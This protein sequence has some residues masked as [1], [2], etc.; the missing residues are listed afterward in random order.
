MKMGRQY[1]VER[2]GKDSER[3][4]F[5]AR[6]QSY[7]GNTLGAL[8]LSGH[9][10][11]RSIYEGMLLPNVRHIPACNEYRDRQVHESTEQYVARKKQELEDMFQEI[12]PHR[13]IGFFLE[14]ISGAVSRISLFSILTL[15]RALVAVLL[16][17]KHPCSI[18]VTQQKCQAHLRL[19]EWFNRPTHITP[20]LVH[21]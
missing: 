4:F 11:R 6:Q 1:H 12:G 9:K 15:L 8:S 5:I 3:L 2:E 16:S 19:V 18:W 13:V 21:R 20:G 14:P 10:A 7:H 17:S